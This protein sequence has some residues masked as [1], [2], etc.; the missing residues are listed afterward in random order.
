M[1]THYKLK[2]KYKQPAVVNTDRSR[3]KTETIL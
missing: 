2:G 3:G 1:E